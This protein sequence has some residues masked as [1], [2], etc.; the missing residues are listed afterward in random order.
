MQKNEELI[1]VEQLQKHGYRVTP[2]RVALLMYLRRLHTPVSA[3][4][5]A[6]NIK[7]SMDKV[8]LYRALHDFCASKIIKEIHLPG[9]TSYYEYIH[10]DD[11]HHHIVCE[12]CGMI[13]DIDMCHEDD[14]QQQALK[15]TTK[16]KTISSHSL[17]FFGLCT[18][19]SA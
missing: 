17:E 10:D 6:K 2:K 3:L 8:T 4:V 7:P 16:F 5:L 14:L 18:A 12:Q 11:H 15:K 13:E 19:C 1:C 9:A